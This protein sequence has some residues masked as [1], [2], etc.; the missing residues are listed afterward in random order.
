M[1]IVFQRLSQRLTSRQTR[2]LANIRSRT[3]PTKPTRRID[4]G[5][6][7]GAAAAAPSYLPPIFLTASKLARSTDDYRCRKRTSFSSN[8]P[9]GPRSLKPQLVRIPDH[10]PA[11]NRRNSLRLFRP[12]PAFSHAP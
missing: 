8:A 10:V 11:A 5:Q 9:R 6:A 12:V 1:G 7:E 3:R 4:V 2:S